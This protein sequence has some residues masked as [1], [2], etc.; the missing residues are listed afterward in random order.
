[1]HLKR[2]IERIENALGNTDTCPLCGAR[3]DPSRKPRAVEAYAEYREHLEEQEAARLFV[4]D[5]PALAAA[6][7]LP[8]PP[9]DVCGICGAD[10]RS[11][12]EIDASRRRIVDEYLDTMAKDGVPADEALAMLKQDAPSLARIGH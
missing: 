4:A 7:E 11:Q 10:K 5:V 3:R 6:L 8:V 12:D 1:M 9:P 2:R